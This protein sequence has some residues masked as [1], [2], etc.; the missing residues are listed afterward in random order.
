MATMHSS[1][2]SC[3]ARLSHRSG[4]KIQFWFWADNN[5]E[6]EKRV[7]RRQKLQ[8][9]KKKGNRLVKSCIWVGRVAVHALSD[10]QYEYLEAKA[11]EM[12]RNSFANHCLKL[13]RFHL[14]VLVA[15]SHPNETAPTFVADLLLKL[16][17]GAATKENPLEEDA[18][19]QQ[20]ANLFL[21]VFQEKKEA[22]NEEAQEMKGTGDG[23]KENNDDDSEEE[24]DDKGDDGEEISSGG[25]TRE[26]EITRS[27]TDFSDQPVSVPIQGKAYRSFSISS[28]RSSARSLSRTSF[29]SSTYAFSATSMTGATADFDETTTASFSVS[30]GSNEV[31]PVSSY[32]S[33]FPSQSRP[34]S[35]LTDS[36]FHSQ[37]KS[38]HSAQTMPPPTTAS[39][40]MSGSRAVRHSNAMK[41]SSSSSSQSRY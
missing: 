5:T 14:L 23:K 9:M 22:D 36:S 18:M 30:A 15:L 33:L 12:E 7:E 4:Q 6:K 25:K 11:Q 26:D 41:G 27:G 37:T 8:R 39:S 34:P 13:L 21:V 1:V 17:H 40:V 29:S 19:L 31:I 24:E 32:C 38:R 16:A 35:Y 3:L 20:N 28:D 2:Q 10:R